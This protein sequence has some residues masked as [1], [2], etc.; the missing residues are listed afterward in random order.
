M[1]LSQMFVGCRKRLLFNIAFLVLRA[2]MLKWYKLF[3]KGQA[4]MIFLFC[5]RLIERAI[6]ICN[7]PPCIDHFDELL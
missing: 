5:L 6:L 1:D 7:V 2:I 3:P 4:Y